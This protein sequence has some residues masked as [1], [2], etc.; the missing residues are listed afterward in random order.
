MA[1]RAAPAVHWHEGMFLRPHHMQAAQRYGAYQDHLRESWDQHYYWGLRSIELDTTALAN[2]RLVVKSLAARMRDG[3]LVNV[4]EDGVLPE[5]DLQPVFKGSEPDKLVKVH[6]A[7]PMLR[8]GQPNVPSGGRADGTR[9][10]AQTLEMEDENTGGS[11]QPIHLRRLN[12]RLLLSTEDTTGYETL[13]IAQVTRSA[14]SPGVILD[15][16]YIPPV[17]SCDAWKVLRDGIMQEIYDRI[18]TAGREQAQRVVAQGVN[19]SSQALGDVRKFEQVR[20]LN[21]AYSVLNVVAMAQGIHPLWAYAELCRLIGQLAIFDETTRRPPS[22]PRYDHDDLGGCFYR[23][24]RH[25]EALVDR[26]EPEYEERPFVGAGWRMQVALE[27]KW[28]LPGWH[29]FVGVK[30]S[31]KPQDCIPILT[32][33]RHLGMKIGSADRVDHI[34]TGGFPGLSFAH[35]PQKPGVLPDGLVYFEIRRETQPEEWAYVQRAL[36]LAIRLNSNRI[37]GNIQ[38]Q[39][40]LTVRIENQ[41]AKMRFTLYALQDKKS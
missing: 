11:P 14:E 36:S 7:I 5:V 12:L 1:T 3:T 19:F 34:F 6:L 35:C 23:V 10:F 4:P 21:E 39:Q 9:Y 41:S 20:I 22:L 32:E 38:D 31:L 27:Q 40:E 26:W 13:Q 16:N 24:K 28:L 8:V 37:I 33:S 18:G 30:T 15:Q 29:M 2:Y 17:L 25:I